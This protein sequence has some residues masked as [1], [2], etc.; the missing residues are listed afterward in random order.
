MGH[1]LA[2]NSSSPPAAKLDMILT[3]QQAARLAG[4][5]AANADGLPLVLHHGTLFRFDRFERTTDYGF[6]FGTLGQAERRLRTMT[7]EEREVQGAGEPRIVSV[8]LSAR[9][10]LVLPHD[11]KHWGLEYVSGIMERFLTRAERADIK[12]ALASKGEDAPARYLAGKATVREALQRAGH[13][14]ILYRNRYENTGGRAVEWSWVAL[15]ANM[16]VQIGEGLDAT[17]AGLP[18]G[19]SPSPGVEPEEHLRVHGGLRT[20]TWELA[21]IKDIR[22]FHGACKAA[23]D[24]V[25]G[26]RAW[27]QDVTYKCLSRA[28]VTVNGIGLK[29]EVDGEA[30]CVSVEALPWGVRQRVHDREPIESIAESLGDMSS[31]AGVLRELEAGTDLNWDRTRFG[32]KADPDKLPVGRLNTKWHPGEPLEVAV[33]RLKASLGPLIRGLKDMS[34]PDAGARM[35]M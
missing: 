1:T 11:P 26:P 30:P 13:D 28:F 24:E 16:I 22:L 4:T 32:A 9:N 10:P 2:C 20:R 34:V 23:V 7:K 18:P 6:H 25:C 15:D 5:R 33:E 3:E 27:K 17:H 8:A 29:I 12:A 19:F 31:F 35:A 21:R 14:S